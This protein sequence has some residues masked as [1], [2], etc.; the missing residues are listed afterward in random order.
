MNTLA[1]TRVVILIIALPLAQVRLSAGS[2]ALALR[3]TP[4]AAVGHAS[5]R[6]RVLVEHDATNRLLELTADSG[7]F[8]QASAIELDGEEAP[9]INEVVFRDMPQGTY[10]IVVRLLDQEG[11]VRAMARGTVVIM[12]P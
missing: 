3:V 12:A 11:R 2:A 4:T 5:I 8:Y 7:D 10:E 9:R 1:F 6:L